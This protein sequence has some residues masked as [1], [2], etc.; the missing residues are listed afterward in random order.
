[1][2]DFGA[3]GWLVDLLVV[4]SFVWLGNGGMGGLIFWLVDDQV[5]WIGYSAFSWMVVSFVGV[6]LG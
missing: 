2:I 1:M 5:G 3:K 6:L 4:W